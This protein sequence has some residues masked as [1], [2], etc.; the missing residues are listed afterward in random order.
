MALRV[1]NNVNGSSRQWMLAMSPLFSTCR[2]RDPSISSLLLHTDVR[3]AFWPQRKV[4]G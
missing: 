2:L 1:V 4:F 3:D